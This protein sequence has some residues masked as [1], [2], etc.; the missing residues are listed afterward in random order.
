MKRLL[1][2]IGLAASVALASEV[3]QEIWI[4]AGKIGGD[5]KTVTEY[6]IGYERMHE[7]EGDML[8]GY[9]ASVKYA[10]MKEKEEERTVKVDEWA[11]D[12]EGLYGMAL[13]N[14][15]HLLGVGGLRLGNVD[16]STTI[17]GLG[18]EA[19]V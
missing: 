17:Y 13:S 6:A 14:D 11:F 15:F 3:S 16:R 7:L 12:F 2:G 10:R 1:F 8:L 4:G 18:I 19:E 9:D 5:V